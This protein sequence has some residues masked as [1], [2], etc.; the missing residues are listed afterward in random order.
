[1][2][3]TPPRAYRLLHVRSLLFI[4]FNKRVGN[5]NSNENKNKLKK[6]RKKKEEKSE[7]ERVYD[8]LDA[9][10]LFSDC[11]LFNIIY[12]IRTL[13]CTYTYVVW[14]K[15]E[16]LQKSWKLYQYVGTPYI[17]VRMILLST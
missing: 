16:L 7:K 13:T 12:I 14:L 4:R 9:I 15:N 8:G 3:S 17:C 6:K 2:R 10:I 1:M 5:E 11:H